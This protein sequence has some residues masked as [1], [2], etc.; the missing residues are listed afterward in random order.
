MI[1]VLINATMFFFHLYTWI[2]FTS[3]SNLGGRPKWRIQLSLA[4]RRSTTSAWRRALHSRNGGRGHDAAASKGK[5]TLAFKTI[6][7]HFSKSLHVGEKRDQPGAG[8]S[9]TVWVIIRKDPLP[10]GRGQKRQA[11]R[12]HKLPQTCFCS[13]VSS[14]WKNTA[15]TYI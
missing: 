7:H 13:A 4:P 6:M 15:V 1:N 8:S 12:F 2:I 9:H 10:H 11:A 14:T 3:G 5:T